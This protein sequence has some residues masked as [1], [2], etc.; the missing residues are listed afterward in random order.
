MSTN[1]A[2][3]FMNG[4]AARAL[5]VD[6]SA[7]NAPANCCAHQALTSGSGWGA[8]QMAAASW[9]LRTACM[10]DTCARTH[11][12]N[13]GSVVRNR[14]DPGRQAPPRSTFH[15]SHMFEVHFSGLLSI[16][17]KPRGSLPLILVLRSFDTEKQTRPPGDA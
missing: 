4:A 10:W 8:A 12:D 17:R 3:G 1:G 11:S 16:R 9:A 2:G 6:D 5:K 7:R 14:Y 15:S 13:A